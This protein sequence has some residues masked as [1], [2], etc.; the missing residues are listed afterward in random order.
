MTS[1]AGFDVAE[2]ATHV[3]VVDEAGKVVF[4]GVCRTEPAALHELFWPD[5][6]RSSGARCWRPVRSPRGWSTG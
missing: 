2:Q 3:C 6:P 5:V 1:Y 4:R